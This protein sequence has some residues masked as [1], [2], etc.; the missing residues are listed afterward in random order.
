MGVSSNAF[1][2]SITR[3]DIMLVLTEAYN[4]NEEGDSLLLR[5][6]RQN[7]IVLCEAVTYRYECNCN[8]FDAFNF[9][10]DKKKSNTQ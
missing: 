3:E 9:L 1:L 6:A 5:D 4:T 8:N 7:S 10:R 2:G